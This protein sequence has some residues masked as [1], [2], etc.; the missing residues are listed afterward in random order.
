M[1]GPTSSAQY[2]YFYGRDGYC[3]SVPIGRAIEVGILATHLDG[4]PLPRQHGGVRVVL[5]GWYGMDS[6]KWLDRIV[7][8]RQPLAAA[9]PYLYTQARQNGNGEVEIQPLPCMQPKS[10]ILTPTQDSVLRKGITE[11]KGLAWSGA[12][13]ILRVEISGDGGITWRPAEI[14]QQFRFEWV[15]GAALSLSR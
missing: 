1:A 11:I 3:R 2:L 15:S 7:A 9:D 13:K 4:M 14:S 10:V 8:A 6:V 5:L 12:Q